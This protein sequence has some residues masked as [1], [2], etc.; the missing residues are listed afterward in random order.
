[1]LYPRVSQKT[2]K[3]KNN[4]GIILSSKLV[5]KSNEYSKIWYSTLCHKRRIHQSWFF[6]LAA[7]N[8][9][10]HDISKSKK[11]FLLK[12][13]QSII[14]L[15]LKDQSFIYELREKRTEKTRVKSSNK[16][17]NIANSSKIYYSYYLE[18]SIYAKLQNYN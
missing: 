7:L 13:I 8:Y 1:M 5:S 15:A 4:T 3:R 6:F 17:R 11:N 12:L 9:E 2:R 14:L 16:K 10:T 18:F